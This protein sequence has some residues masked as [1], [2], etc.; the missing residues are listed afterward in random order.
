MFV[1]LESGP[2]ETGPT[3]PVA[4]ALFVVAYIIA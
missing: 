1:A 4:M 2:V 3:G